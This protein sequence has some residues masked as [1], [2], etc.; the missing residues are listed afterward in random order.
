MYYIE[1]I[2]FTI[3]CYSILFFNYLYS[4]LSIQSKH[5]FVGGLKIFLISNCIFPKSILLFFIDNFFIFDFLIIFYW[6]SFN[7]F[8]YSNYILFIILDNFKF[9]TFLFIL[10]KLIII[11]FNILYLIYIFVID[12][13][14]FDVCLIIFICIIATFALRLILR[15]ISGELVLDYME[16]I[17]KK[18]TEEEIEKLWLDYLEVEW[19]V[20]K[21][22]YIS[23]VSYLVIFYI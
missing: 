8:F 10:K 5:I 1:Y 7:L 20:Y 19:I 13:K 14:H 9:D 12:D 2:F 23:C 22:F 11:I 4:Y 6:L 17:G 18:F 15:V 16:D 21:L 3:D